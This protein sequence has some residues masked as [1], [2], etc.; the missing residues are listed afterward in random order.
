V[1][2]QTKLRAV[3]ARAAGMALV[4]TP[5]V[6]IVPLAVTA[7][8]QAPSAALVLSDATPDHDRPVTIRGQVEPGQAGQAVALE[9]APATGAWQVLAT[10]TV[11]GD[12]RYSFTVRLSRSGQVRAAVGGAQAPIGQ[13]L[14]AESTATRTAPRS[15]AIPARVRVSTRSLD[16]LAGE[17]A[18]VAG[19]L[20]P[21]Q[22]GRLVRLER[23]T[24]RTW[25]GVASTRTPAAGRYR[26]THR[27]HATVTAAVRL[28]FAGDRDNGRTV[29]PLGRMSAY[30]AAVASYYTLYGGALACGGRLGYDSL[31]VAHRSL[32]CGTPVTVRYRGRVVHARVMDRGPFSGGREFD[33]AGA[34]ARRLGFS[35]VQTVWV[36]H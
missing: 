16:V 22:A 13:A 33:L 3:A 24:G 8:A 10:S 6:A 2:P 27:P 28:V 23:R 21:A 5:V 7:Q 15:V 9:F 25:R 11:A 1:K 19:H 36:A 35:G 18:V 14:A 32:P 20:L 34:V 4:L 31:V 29:H 30:R 26:L 12:G 17:P